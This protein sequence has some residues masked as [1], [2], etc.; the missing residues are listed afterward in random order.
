M[1]MNSG[2]PSADM[3]LRFLGDQMWQS[4]A[5]WGE[6]LRLQAANQPA[7][8]DWHVDYSAMGRIVEAFQ[9]LVKSEQVHLADLLKTC[10]RQLAPF[11]DPFRLS[12]SSHRWLDLQREREESY[13][14]WLA[15]LL[16]RMDSAE[17][18]LR[19]FDLE[20]TEFGTLVGK[21]KPTIYREVQCRVSG[22]EQRR[23]DIVIQFGDAGILLVE[24]KVREIEVAGG[25]ENLPIYCSWLEEQQPDSKRRYT[26]LLVPSP[27]ESPSGWEVR[28]WDDISLNL[29]LQAAVCVDTI[30]RSSV[31][32]DN[33]VV[34]PQEGHEHQPSSALFA[35][36]L[37][38]FAGA[39][40]Q[41]VLGLE[42]RGGTISTPQTALYLERFLQG[43][44]L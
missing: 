43:C 29:R 25:A 21:Q 40:E 12:I 30:R 14:D 17:Q 9:A 8:V 39:V 23:L 6:A 20:N 37:L 41:N 44:Q 38:C 10:D 26:I 27:I 1:K 2:K 3:R 5:K 22:G 13:S 15:W 7:G 19:I 4:Y 11:S 31:L 42:G 36:M 28:S 16:E 33:P 34:H 35:A 24:V 18:V 32:A